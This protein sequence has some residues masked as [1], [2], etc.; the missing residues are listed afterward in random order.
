M[1]HQALLGFQ[2][3]EPTIEWL[4]GGSLIHNRFVIT[5]AHCFES[6]KHGLVKF[7]RLGAINVYELPSEDS[8]RPKDYN[9]EERIHH[10]KFILESLQ[11]DIGLLKLDKNVEFSIYISPICLPSK[12]EIPDPKLISTGWGS[13][14]FSKPKTDWLI[15]VELE[16]INGCNTSQICTGSKSEIENCPGDSGSGL[17]IVHPIHYRRHLLVGISSSG[18]NCKTLG[19][20]TRVYSYLDWITDIVWN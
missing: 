9:V 1:S 12:F 17:M 4:C 8:I 14:G 10:P 2:S 20:Y 11:N 16:E 7:V 15:T 5:A 19:I 6:P 18:K 13:V 3:V